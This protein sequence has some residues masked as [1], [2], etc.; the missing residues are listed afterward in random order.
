MLMEDAVLVGLSAVQNNKVYRIP[1]GI[2]PWCRT[3]PEAAIQMIWAGKLFYPERF[4]DVD[5]A[6]VAKDFY[7]SIY[8]T[9]VEDWVIEGILAG[10]LCPTGK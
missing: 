8:G 5:I 7:R 10:K 1:Q 2:F 9:E 4:E 3:G 6:T